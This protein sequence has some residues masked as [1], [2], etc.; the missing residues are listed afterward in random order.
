MSGRIQPGAGGF[1]A[2]AQEALA[3]PSTTRATAA[4]QLASR[5]ARPAPARLPLTVRHA[6]V[7]A[8][9]PRTRHA[10]RLAARGLADLPA[11]PSALLADHDPGIGSSADAATEPAPVIIEIAAAPDITSALQAPSGAADPNAQ[12]GIPGSGAPALALNQ[13]ALGS[14]AALATEAAVLQLPLA[15]LQDARPVAA[16]AAGSTMAQRM[17]EVASAARELAALHQPQQEAAAALVAARLATAPPTPAST[18]AALKAKHH[19]L[20]SQRCR[21]TFQLQGLAIEM[22]TAVHPALIANI[23][24]WALQADGADAG[25]AAHGPLFPLGPDGKAWPD[26]GSGTLDRVSVTFGA[27]EHARHHLEAELLASPG[28]QTILSRMSLLV[29]SKQLMLA[30]IDSADRQLLESLQTLA[31]AHQLTTPDMPASAAALAAELAPHVDQRNNAQL[32][33]QWMALAGEAERGSQLRNLVLHNE[34][35]HALEAK[36]QD[37]GLQ[38]YL[39]AAAGSVLPA[40]V[41]ASLHSLFANLAGDGIATQPDFDPSNT[42]D[43]V[44]LGGTMSGIGLGT[45]VP[46]VNHG[47]VPTLIAGLELAGARTLVATDPGKIYPDAPKMVCDE[48]L[49]PH[50]LDADTHQC[51]QDAV[52][53]QRDN[54]SKQL[55]E[56][57]FAGTSGKTMGYLTYGLGNGLRVLAKAGGALV[58]RVG[59]TGVSQ[60]LASSAMLVAQSRQRIDGYP[61]FTLGDAQGV[62]RITAGLKKFNALDEA[63]PRE[64]LAS[65]AGGIQSQFLSKGIGLLPD[66]PGVSKTVGA[67]ARTGAGMVPLLSTI[68]ALTE[69]NKSRE[70]ERAQKAGVIAPDHALR[71]T[72]LAAA[73][74]APRNVNGAHRGHVLV[75]KGTNVFA[76][77]NAVLTAASELGPTAAADGVMALTDALLGYNT[78][79]RKR[80]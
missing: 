48:D 40:A 5:L 37:K 52:L 35:T 67:A 16:G 38:Y 7:P 12:A 71:R 4:S 75:G 55:E 15:S 17:S 42:A 8:V 80:S 14:Q 23:I 32:S 28:D 19:S 57:T 39:R 46:V 2:A 44:G 43:S 77:G 29:S 78:A 6:G 68:F 60:G 47:V 41:A 20:Q 45:A 63:A 21:A 56:Y 18:L 27:Y 49:L 58:A 31:E 10:V 74:L 25:A 62:A 33:A 59:Q 1:P 30:E 11:P 69:H 65:V 24:K 66:I 13:S 3:G 79:A 73:N 64:F 70:L 54:F 9:A 26:D 61:A 76:S 22:A 50:E 72:T 34:Y 53:I 36:H 51:Q